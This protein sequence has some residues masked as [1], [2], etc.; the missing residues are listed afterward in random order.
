MVELEARK[1]EPVDPEPD[2]LVTPVGE[3]P[4]CADDE[5]GTVVALDALEVVNPD[6]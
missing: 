5:P 6:V 3:T 1:P 4:V 2:W